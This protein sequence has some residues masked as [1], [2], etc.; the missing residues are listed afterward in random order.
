[1]SFYPVDAED[2]AEAW[3]TEETSKI[4][5]SEFARRMKLPRLSQTIEGGPRACDAQPAGLRE[6]AF[7]YVKAGW[8]DELAKIACDELIDHGAD[9]MGEEQLRM[10]IGL[11]NPSPVPAAAMAALHAELLERVR[12]LYSAILEPPEARW[13]AHKRV[14]EEGVAGYDDEE[15][16]EEEE[17]EEEE[18][19]EEEGEEEEGEEEAEE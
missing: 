17:G 2:E 5:A 16:G 4:L 15:E 7:S 19:E 12:H 10:L 3:L 11:K 8:R 14:R 18:S 1:M 9:S 13:A 6:L